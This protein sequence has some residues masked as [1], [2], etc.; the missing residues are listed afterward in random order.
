MTTETGRR[1]GDDAPPHPG[2]PGANP[3]L[4]RLA[5]VVVMFALLPIAGTRAVW[6]ADEGALLYQA[7]SVAH[8][9]GWSF[10][11]PFPEADPSGTYFPIHLSSW[12]PA[13]APDPDRPE[14]GCRPVA[15]GCRY[16]VLAKH[17]LF[18]R[19]LAELFRIGGYGLLIALSVAA[20]VGAA[21]AASRLAGR[22]DRAAATPALWITGLASPLFIDSYVAWGHT[23]GAALIGWAAYGLLSHDR[24][25]LW[26]PVGLLALLVACLVRT[27]A[28]IAGLAIG[29]GL[30]A[31]A[32]PRGQASGR[33]RERAL[34]GLAAL[35]TT[36]VGLAIDAATAIDTA[37]AVEPVGFDAAHGF[38]AG[39]IEAFAIT[40]LQPAYGS[41]PV[42]LLILGAAMM[43]LMAGVVARRGPDGSARA[44]VLLVVAVA[45]LAVRFAVSPAALVPGLV[46]AFPV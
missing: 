7:D 1:S 32:L 2:R 37:G 9:R 43:T 46:M 6:S 25:S 39:R 26:R 19:S 45:A 8:G 15:D 29:L 11:H 17:A 10:P 22:I 38:V 28:P 4:H 18:L 40:W 20:S 23:I 16:I 35:I 3:G 24:K 34:T 36:V 27:E 12:D 30:L 14:T 21:V 41:D 42:D 13:A 5:L 33:R 31:V 44:T